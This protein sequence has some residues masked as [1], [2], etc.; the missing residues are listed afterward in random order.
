MRREEKGRKHGALV[1]SCFFRNT[2]VEPITLNRPLVQM[3]QIK[4]ILELNQTTSANGRTDGQTD[5]RTD[6]FEINEVRAATT[7]DPTPTVPPTPEEPSPVA[8]VATLVVMEVGAMAAV[9]MAA[10]AS[11]THNQG[12]KQI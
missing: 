5:R 7:W 11:T 2:N 9:A 12:L 4:G 8:A 6:E 1:E 10:V 3:G